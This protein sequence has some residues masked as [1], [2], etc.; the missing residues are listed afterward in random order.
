MIR[1]RSLR[2]GELALWLSRYLPERLI[3]KVAIVGV[4][5]LRSLRG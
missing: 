5:R 4:R 1:G 2:S 3:A